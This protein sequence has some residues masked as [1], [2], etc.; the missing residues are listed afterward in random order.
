MN[1][2]NCDVARCEGHWCNIKQYCARYTAPTKGCGQVVMMSAE[3]CIRNNNI[4][5]I[6]N[7][8]LDVS[9]KS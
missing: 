9:K 7:G 1:K 2:L 8:R 3:Y 5:H 6:S 4:V